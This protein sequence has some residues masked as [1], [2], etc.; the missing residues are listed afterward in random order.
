MY[1]IMYYKMYGE[2]ISRKSYG[3]FDKYKF[4]LCNT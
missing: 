2:T 4:D 3:K 1:M